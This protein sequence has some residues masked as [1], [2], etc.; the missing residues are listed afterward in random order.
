MSSLDWN[1]SGDD[2]ASIHIG[3]RSV[4]TRKLSPSDLSSECSSHELYG[5]SI[6][7][8]R[9][10]DPLATHRL[11]LRDRHGVVAATLTIA[12]TPPP[13]PRATEPPAPRRHVLSVVAEA[14]PNRMTIGGVH[15]VPRDVTLVPPSSPFTAIEGSVEGTGATLWQ[16]SLPIPAVNNPDLCDRSVALLRAY[17]TRMAR[18]TSPGPAV[19]PGELHAAAALVTTIEVLDDLES[20]STKEADKCRGIAGCTIM[21]HSVIATMYYLCGGVVVA[22]PPSHPTYKAMLAKKRSEKLAFFSK[23]CGMLFNGINT[24]PGLDASGDVAVTVHNVTSSRL[25]YIEFVLKS[26]PEGA[27]V[28]FAELDPLCEVTRASDFLRTEFNELSSQRKEMFCRMLLAFLQILALHGC[29]LDIRSARSFHGLEFMVA[30]SDGETGDA[31]AGLT[32]D[33]LGGVGLRLK[34]EQGRPGL[35]LNVWRRDEKDALEYVIPVTHGSHPCTD[36]FKTSEELQRMARAPWDAAVFASSNRELQESYEGFLMPRDTVLAGRGWLEKAFVGEETVHRELCRIMLEPCRGA[37][38]PVREILGPLSSQVALVL[39]THLCGCNSVD[40][41]SLISVVLGLEAKE[42]D[43]SSRI[44]FKELPPSV[45]GFLEQNGKSARYYDACWDLDVSAVR[46]AHELLSSF[47]GEWS[48]CSKC[49]RHLNILSLSSIPPSAPTPHT[50]PTPHTRMPPGRV[51]AVRSIYASAEGVAEIVRAV[52][53]LKLSYHT[54][55]SPTNKFNSCI[56]IN[57]TSG[58]HVEELS[59]LLDDLRKRGLAVSGH[60]SDAGETRFR[61]PGIA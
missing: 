3:V 21:V 48:W 5:V 60:A 17:Q 26:L 36:R 41:V 16:P 23:V 14:C 19:P 51:N 59:V 57:I 10:G 43:S 2:R 32:L 53:T 46:D 24:V 37:L 49:A 8:P 6:L 54:Y 35:L 28:V 27:V 31:A 44:E 12:L 40:D 7:L 58:V 50:H 34:T 47:G 11:E 38:C 45:R 9:R 4:P 20:A 15:H 61:N 56:N 33:D 22:I 29:T 13:A 18:Q 39:A 1:H 25:G 30:A 42:R 52:C 55:A